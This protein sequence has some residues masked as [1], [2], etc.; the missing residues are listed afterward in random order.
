MATLTQNG[1][2]FDR[3]EACLTKLQDIAKGKFVDLV[4]VGEELDVDDSSILGR[5]LGIV[6]ELDALNE[7]YVQ[8]V[9]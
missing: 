5:V 6:A 7:E 4:P 8:I 1:L 9:L 3:L 2:E